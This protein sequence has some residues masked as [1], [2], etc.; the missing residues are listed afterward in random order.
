[1]L[2]AGIQAGSELDPRFKHSGVSA[3]LG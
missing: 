2:L 1:M 3:P